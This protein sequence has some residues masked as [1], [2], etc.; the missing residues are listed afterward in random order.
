MKNRK[1]QNRQIGKYNIQIDAGLISK[2]NAIFMYSVFNLKTLT[3]DSS[4]RV[5]D[6]HLNGVSRFLYYANFFVCVY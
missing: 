1:K 4:G 6:C 3:F 5:Y 2:S